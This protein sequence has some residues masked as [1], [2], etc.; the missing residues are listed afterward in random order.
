[1]TACPAGMSPKQLP[2]LDLEFPSFFIYHTVNLEREEHFKSEQ[3][4]VN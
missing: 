3:P 4:K 1:M 2:L